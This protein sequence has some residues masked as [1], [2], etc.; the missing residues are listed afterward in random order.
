MPFLTICRRCNHYIFSTTRESANNSIVRHFIKSHKRTPVPLPDERTTHRILLYEVPI[1]E[2][3][4][5]WKSKTVRK[6]K[7][8]APIISDDYYM[9]VIS[10]DDYNMMTKLMNDRKTAPYF[11]SAINT[12]L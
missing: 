7:F 4:H 12:K 1:G 5:K 3:A 10:Y 11:W 2:N 8:R 6:W 9:L